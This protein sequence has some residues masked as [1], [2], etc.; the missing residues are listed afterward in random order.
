[1]W[2]ALRLKPVSADLQ[3][4]SAYAD[5]I[6]HASTQVDVWSPPAVSDLSRSVEGD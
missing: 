5:L 1:F 3:P 4:K 2:G 6:A